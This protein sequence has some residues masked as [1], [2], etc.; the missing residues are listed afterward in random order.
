MVYIMKNDTR[1]CNS[2]NKSMD[3]SCYGPDK[4]VISGFKAVC[5]K[6]VNLINK[7]FF[8]TRDGLFTRIYDGQVRRSRAKGID[9]PSYSLENLREWG[10]SRENFDSLFIAWVESNYNKWLVPSC[11]RIDDYKPY[12]LDN[13]QLMT[14]GENKAKGDLDRKNGLN[15][16]I[17]KS[18][19]QINDH[20][21]VVSTFYS[22][23][24]AGRATGIDYKNISACCLGKRLNAGGFRWKFQ[25]EQDRLA[26]E[27]DSYKGDE[28]D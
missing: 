13:I 17:S 6:C 10:F 26:D 12:T 18:V 24:Q 23:A 19:E 20:E 7:R 22:I 9:L 2:C 1:I 3:L 28:D 27:R 15:N 14:W 16:K 8:R 4:S 25:K 11:D 5:K 21:C